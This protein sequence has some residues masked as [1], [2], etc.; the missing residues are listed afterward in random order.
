[1]SA[2]DTF[3][4]K[5]KDVYDVASKKTGELVEVSKLK[6]ECVKVNNEIKKLY[7]KLGSCVY[8][9]MKANYDNKDVVDGLVEEIDENLA[10]LSVLNQ[11]LSDIKNVVICKACGAKNPE[12]NYFC[13]KCGS[14]IKNE[15]N[16]ADV[17]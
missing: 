9:M 7:E 10:K 13:S 3:M 17:Q 12:A 16:N 2:F 5:A 4:D 6:M 11:K 14:R 15:F 1:M 8:S